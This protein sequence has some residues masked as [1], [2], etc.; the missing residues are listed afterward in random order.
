M[1]QIMCGFAKKEEI[2]PIKN[3]IQPLRLMRIQ[4]WIQ[5]ITLMRIRKR[6]MTF[7]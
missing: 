3:D 1:G 7:I 6:T 2:K 5:L 4:F